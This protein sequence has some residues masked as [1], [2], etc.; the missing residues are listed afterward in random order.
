MTLL[1]YLKL[2]LI[3]TSLFLSMG[4]ASAQPAAPAATPKIPA[5]K[6]AKPAPAPAPVP[7]AQP[8]TPAVEGEQPKT[9]N[10]V[11][12]GNW[13]VYWYGVNKATY[14]NIAQASGGSGITTFMGALATLDKEACS[15]FGTVIDAADASYQ[16]GPTSKTISMSAY[17]IMRVQCKNSQ[18]WIE[19]FGLPAG[20][21]LMTGRATII[22]ANGQRKYAPVALGR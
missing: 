20:K 6:N 12:Q 18:I 16:D 1:R 14:M 7:P 8:S 21:V 17:V 5:Q 22:D 15:T 2:P 19:A 9:Q 11:L 4:D 13:N 3:G 10:H